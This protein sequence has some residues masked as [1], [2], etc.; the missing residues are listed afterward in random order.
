MASFLD[1]EI[2]ERDGI[3]VVKKG[4]LFAP[5]SP[6]AMA[7]GYYKPPK[8]IELGKLAID[9][10]HFQVAGYHAIGNDIWA[11]PMSDGSV[12]LRFH[13]Y[14]SD[15]NETYRKVRR[16]IRKI[17]PYCKVKIAC[18]DGYRLPHDLKPYHI[19][20]EESKGGGRLY[21]FKSPNDGIVC[22]YSIWQ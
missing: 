11:Y 3:L 20:G 1:K 10:E 17:S 22:F 21:W 14:Y 13:H 4:D 12:I 16:H 18:C 6:Q 5:L 9:S 7:A 2:V 8:I 19:D 15:M